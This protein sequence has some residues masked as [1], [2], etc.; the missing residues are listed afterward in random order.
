MNEDSIR[1]DKWLWYG[2]FCRSRSDAARFVQ[3]GRV[4]VNRVA[5]NKPAAPVKPGDVLTFPQ[6]S[7]IRVV[8]VLQS[9]RRRGPPAEARSLYEE[10]ITPDRRVA[11]MASSAPPAAGMCRAGHAGIE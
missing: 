7:G 9:G 5:V 11:P 10:M 2:R 1:L 3:A 8:R 6:G 4:R